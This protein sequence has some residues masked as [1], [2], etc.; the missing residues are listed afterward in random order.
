MDRD[1]AI[2]NTYPPGGVKDGQGDGTGGERQSPDGH[3]DD[4]AVVVVMKTP[5][6]YD[7]VSV[8]EPEGLHT[9]E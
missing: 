8:K 6:I 3:Y 2:A 4:G 1:V 5:F 9:C 7:P